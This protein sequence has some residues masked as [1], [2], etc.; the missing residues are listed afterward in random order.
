MMKLAND[1]V[2]TSIVFND[3]G[4]TGLFHLVMIDNRWKIIK[5]EFG[6]I[7]RVLPQDV[8]VC[9]RTIYFVHN[10]FISYQQTAYESWQRPV[11]TDTY[12]ILQIILDDDLLAGWLKGHSGN[13]SI[14]LNIKKTDWWIAQLSHRKWPLFLMSN[15]ISCIASILTIYWLKDSYTLKN[16]PFWN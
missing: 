8:I 6:K 3:I 5:H 9:S 16:M 10:V 2:K 11:K 7:W 15:H 14:K 4:D 13:N 12:T 1:T